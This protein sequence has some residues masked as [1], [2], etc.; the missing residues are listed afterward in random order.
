MQGEK[1]RLTYSAMLDKVDRDGVGLTDWEIEFV[2][3]LC[4]QRERKQPMTEKQKAA[5]ERIFDN[6]C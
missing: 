3:S 4:R 6:R 1:D 5:L 2:E